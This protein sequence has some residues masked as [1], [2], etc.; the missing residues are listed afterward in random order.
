MLIYNAIARRGSLPCKMITANNDSAQP[1]VQQQREAMNNKRA[2]T[3]VA[4]N[5]VNH[6]GPTKQHRTE[7]ID[8]DGSEKMVKTSGADT[9]A[10][11]E[12]DTNNEYT[13]KM[14]TAK[15]MESEPEN[16]HQ[17][18]NQT[19]CVT[20]ESNI[21]PAA[22]TKLCFDCM[23]NDF[24]G[25]DQSIIYTNS[26]RK[27]IHEHCTKNQNHILPGMGFDYRFDLDEK[28]KSLKHY[29]LCNAC[30]ERKASSVWARKENCYS[31][32]VFCGECEI[33][34]GD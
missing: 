34:G 15:Q 25:L 32:F 28:M 8:G 22:S 4:N 27:L 19:S 9:A 26:Q 5:D 1:P 3:A 18:Q 23:G 30:N 7:D 6:P 12:D 2:I 24:N 11:M 10:E 21:N 13:A 17:C 29:L 33:K 20:V 31:L 14:L 16:C